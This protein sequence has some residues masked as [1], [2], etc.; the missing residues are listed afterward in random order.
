MT[1]CHFFSRQPKEGVKILQKWR[2]F[3]IMYMYGNIDFVKRKTLDSLFPCLTERGNVSLIKTQWF[4]SFRHL[5]RQETAGFC[6][7]LHFRF[8]EDVEETLSSDTT[9]LSSPDTGFDF[10]F[11]V[12]SP[13]AS[14]KEE[15]TVESLSNPP[16][17]LSLFEDSSPILCFRG[18][19]ACSLL[20]VDLAPL[21][22]LLSDAGDSVISSSDNFCVLDGLPFSVSSTASWLS[23][24]LFFFRFFSFPFFVSSHFL[25]RLQHHERNTYMT[26]IL[27]QGCQKLCRQHSNHTRPPWSL[28]VSL[29]P[30]PWLLS[31]KSNAH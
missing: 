8:L 14:L 7:V 28:T 3:A 1:V 26:T 16:F 11:G 19:P 27:R 12:V 2:A 29:P 21:L 9:M 20:L 13:D 31:Y 25:L 4:S 15:V 30:L 24:F 17:S 22:C 6:G 23:V 5:F 10:F 18:E